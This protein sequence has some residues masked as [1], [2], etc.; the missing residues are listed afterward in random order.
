MDQSPATSRYNIINSVKISF[1]QRKDNLR[2]QTRAST[3][4][5]SAT[6]RIRQVG[7]CCFE[8]HTGRPADDYDNG[9]RTAGNIKRQRISCPPPAVTFRNISHLTRHAIN[10]TN[11]FHGLITSIPSSPPLSFPSPL[12]PTFPCSYPIPQTST[13]LH[14]DCNSIVN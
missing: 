12:F 3:Q 9:S 4:N 10:Y 14:P 11:R 8:Q 7:S 2:A 5:R 1:S 13:R 6:W